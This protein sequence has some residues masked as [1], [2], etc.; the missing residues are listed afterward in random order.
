MLFIF[1]PC[2]VLFFTPCFRKWLSAKRA[3]S[4]LSE[5]VTAFFFSCRY[6][7]LAMFAS[8]IQLFYKSRV[9]CTF[10]SRSETSSFGVTQYAKRL[11]STTFQSQPSAPGTP[12]PHS[13][14][15]VSQPS[16]PDVSA[17][18][19]SWTQTAAQSVPTHSQR[20]GVTLAHGAPPEYDVFIVGGGVTGTALLYLLSNFTSKRIAN[21][22]LQNQAWLIVLNDSFSFSH[23]DLLV[24]LPHRHSAHRTCRAKRRLCDCR[25]GAC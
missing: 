1:D 10:L 3:S 20:S 7:L 21:C 12:K 8:R 23:Y 13:Q 14:A 17:A 4:F 25:V 16:P 22:F 18:A 15:A 6:C 19:P 2:A 11:S 9:A 24:V 5:G